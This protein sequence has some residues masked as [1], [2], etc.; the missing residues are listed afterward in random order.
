MVTSLSG[1]RFTVRPHVRARRG[2][3][4]IELLAAMALITLIMAILSQAFVEGLE[5][6]RNLKGIGDL[7]ERLRSAVIKLRSDVLAARQHTNRFIEDTL[8]SGA[9]DGQA[10]AALRLQFQAIS[11]EATDL[12]DGLRS[13]GRETTNP[14]AQRLLARM[15]NILAAIKHGSIVIV[16]LIDLL[17]LINPP[18]PP[19]PNDL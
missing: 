10:A 6:F 7:N 12:D 15:L 11:E 19:L 4:I 2:Y 17:N 16:E 1:S 3:T 18:P 9:P 13:V 5:T 14:A 8:L